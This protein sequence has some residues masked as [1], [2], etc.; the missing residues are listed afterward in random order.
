MRFLSLFI[1]LVAAGVLAIT[2][3]R[4][5]LLASDVMGRKL[6][7][8][9]ME[10]KPD[11]YPVAILAGGCFWCL[12][13][14]FRGK[15]GVL[16]TRVGY[17]GGSLDNP[18]YEDMHDGKSGHAEAVEITYDPDQITYEGLLDYF[19]TKAHDPTQLNRQG[20]DVGTQYR[21][22]VFYLDE[23]QKKAAQAMIEKVTKDGVYKK[24]IVTTLEPATTFW[25]AENYHQQYYEKYE[26]KYGKPHIRDWLKRQSKGLGIKG[27]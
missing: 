15:D 1:L 11:D 22:T 16:Y 24:P 14:E 10:S 12:E 5:P 6:S 27:D 4:P 8:D 18:R 26:E 20:V 2:F 23:E 9:L 3:M 17:I 25:L 21:S 19:F 13:S 7:D